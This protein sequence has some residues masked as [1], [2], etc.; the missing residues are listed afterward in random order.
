MAQLILHICAIGFT[1]EKFLIAQAE[2]QRQKG[3]RVGF[4]FSPSPETPRLKEL[5]F[6]VYE[7]FIPREMNPLKDI[8]A[9]WQMQEL[10]SRLKPILIHTHTSK[11][12]LVGRFAAWFAKVPH[13]VHTVHGFPFTEGMQKF[14]YWTFVFVERFLAY[15]THAM[16][17]QSAEDVVLGTRYKILPRDKKIQHIGN[18]IDLSRFAGKSQSPHPNPLHA[19][20]N[21]PKDAVLILTIGRVNH[22]KGYY[23]L[24]ES[25]PRL[26]DQVHLICVGFDEGHQEIL[27]GKVSSFGLQK[28]VHWLGLRHDIPILMASCDCFVLASHRE[29]VPRSLIEAQAMGLPCIATDIRGCREVIIHNQTGLLVKPKNVEDLQSALQN[30]LDNPNQAKQLAS[31]GQQRVRTYFDEKIVCD[32]IWQGYRNLLHTKKEGESQ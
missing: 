27:E 14:K 20:L 6:E 5:G 32:K 8:R 11:G 1:A 24:I 29:G 17:S 28:R 21:L 23:E 26:P 15:F 22:E 7:L 10:L 19:E 12:G 25:L 4:V 18:G 13:V 30:L 16:F 2:H 31:A 3:Y 9:I